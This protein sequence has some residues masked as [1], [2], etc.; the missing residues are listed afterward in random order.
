MS[1]ARHADDLRQ[2]GF[3]RAATFSWERAALQT[4]DVYREALL[5]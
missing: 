5:A 1:D 4:R 2:K 3:A